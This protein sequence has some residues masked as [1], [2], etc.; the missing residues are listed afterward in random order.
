[1]RRT[2][3]GALRR[4][5]G[6]WPREACKERLFWKTCS[7][8]AF[9]GGFR[10]RAANSHLMRCGSDHAAAPAR[11]VLDLKQRRNSLQQRRPPGF[12]KPDQ[13][14]AVVRARRVLPDIGEI[15]VLRDE[16][17]PAG[18]GGLPHDLIVLSGNAFGWYRV[19]VVPQFSQPGTSWVGRF[20][21][22]LILIAREPRRQADP[23]APTPR[24]T[25]WPHG[26]PA[27]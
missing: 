10:W 19:H 15:Q 14:K 23:L 21:S 22:S 13:Q 20:S 17:A 12:G 27:L 11:D 9:A 16:E 4:G 1:M 26:C 5:L 25:Q 2:G 8:V 6:A 3:S 7:A 24:R 18:L